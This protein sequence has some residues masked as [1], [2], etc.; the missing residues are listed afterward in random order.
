MLNECCF[1]NT[2]NLK[3]KDFQTEVANLGSTVSLTLPYKFTYSNGLAPVWQPITQRLTQLTC[4][5]AGNVSISTTNQ[6]RIFNFDNSA[7][8]FTTM[9]AKGAIVTLG[10]SIETNIGKNFDSSVTNQDPSSPSYGLKNTFSGPYRFYGNG[11][12]PISSFNQLAEMQMFY[13]NYGAVANGKFNVYL[14]D[15]IIPSIVGSGLTQ[16]ANNRNNE[17]ADNWVVGTFGTPPVNYY[18]SNL[19][20]THTSGTLGVAGTVLTVVSTN[21]QTGQAVTQ[22]T[23]SGAGTSSTAIFSGDMGEFNDGVSGQPDMR[24]LTFINNGTSE[25]VNPV[26]FRVTADAASSGGTVTFNITPALNWAGGQNKN[27]NHAIAAGMQIT[28]LPSHR[29]GGVINDDAF[30]V[31]MPQLPDQSPFY[32]SSKMD[33]ESGASICLCYGALFD[34][35]QMGFKFM[36]V[37]GSLIV[38]DYSMRVIVPMSQ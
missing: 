25:S 3:F 1:L 13:K 32:S 9:L 19:L 20:P 11:T 6:Q 17:I 10:N 29:A 24:Y 31:A 26:Q 38:P 33:E 5:Q 12:T 18:Q 34:Q 37:W 15:Y 14:P 7:E 27:I 28:F 30:F 22:I 4:D 8:E 16:F 23:C 36:S 21:D 35:N 2:A